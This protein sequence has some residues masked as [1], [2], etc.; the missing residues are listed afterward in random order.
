[1]GWSLNMT[2]LPTGRRMVG[3]V[4]KRGEGR[5]VSS[6][7]WGSAPSQLGF[8]TV[9]LLKGQHLPKTPTG[10]MFPTVTLGQELHCSSAEIFRRC[11]IG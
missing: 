8:T 1:M 2:D 7:R 5:D 9:A 4:P 11:N 10:C 6:S 3:S